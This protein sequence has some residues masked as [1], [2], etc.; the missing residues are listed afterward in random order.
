M[1]AEKTPQ[2]SESNSL[3]AVDCNNKLKTKNHP[4]KRKSCL[5]NFT[6]SHHL[7]KGFKFSINYFPPED[8]Y[9]FIKIHQNVFVKLIRIAQSLYDK[10]MKNKLL[11]NSSKNRKDFKL[12]E[13]VDSEQKN[14]LKNTK[15]L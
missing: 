15:A 4:P 7:Q 1:V 13:R 10:P 12:G 6:A 2:E 3:K 11:Q 5:R 9:L 14:H 8:S